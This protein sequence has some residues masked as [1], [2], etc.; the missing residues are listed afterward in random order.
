MSLFNEEQIKFI[1]EWAQSGKTKKWFLYEKETYLDPENLALNAGL[2]VFGE[3]IG[4]GCVCC[5]AVTP[6]ERKQR[7]ELFS[8]YFDAMYEVSENDIPYADSRNEK[9]DM[10]L[11]QILAEEWKDVRRDNGSRGCS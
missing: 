9:M 4:C 8:S 11:V 2:D 3:H 1:R 5:T 10:E 7:A 6:E